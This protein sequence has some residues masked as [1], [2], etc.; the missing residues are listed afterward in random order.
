MIYLQCD[1]TQP[2]CRK[3]IKARRVCRGMTDSAQTAYYSENFFASGQ[4]KRPRGPRPKRKAEDASDEASRERSL[5][6][7]LKA[8]AIAEY[9][10]NHLTVPKEQPSLLRGT[11]SDLLP[12]WTAKAEYPILD[13]AVSAMALILYSRIHNCPPAAT[14]ACLEY[15]CLLQIVRKSTPELN[16]HTIDSY[17]LAIFFM[18]RYED[19]A[20]PPNNS[21]KSTSTEHHNGAIAALRLWKDQFS[22]VK[23]PSNIMKHTRRGLIRSALLRKIALPEFLRDGAL[24]GEQGIDFEYDN[25]TV[26]IVH[27]RER[28]AEL[29]KLQQ[30]V[31]IDCHERHAALEALA[32]EAQAIDEDLQD[33]STRFPSS[34]AY[35]RHQMPENSSSSAYP[36]PDFFRPIVY[37]CSSVEYAGVWALY[38]AT[39]V[40]VN[41]TRREALDAA[42]FLPYELILDC[43]STLRSTADDLA[44]II[45]FCVGN[46][47]LT[48]N[49]NV[50]DSIEVLAKT[51]FF[52]SDIRSVA[53]PLSIVVGLRL[54]CREQRSWF[55]ALLVRVGKEFGI[56]I[57]E[58]TG[59]FVND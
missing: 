3:C 20:H 5:A 36:T 38:F 25:I 43:T 35:E 11:D 37:T 39:R 49:K 26:R 52:F 19:A 16:E 29:I 30:G 4:I 14:E 2:I 32:K 10:N 42:K 6:G 45:P 59:S 57:L 31:N 47:K 17:L 27:I 58:S 8:Q 41:E 18:S 24:Y 46:V 44:S 33:M 34:W 13:H 55:G 9:L 53:W 22:H 48:Q 51:K 15:E 7:G 23:S 1:E 54:L 40:V 28:L 56:G 12:L 50:P 21:S